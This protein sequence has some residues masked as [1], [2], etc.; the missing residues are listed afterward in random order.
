MNKTFPQPVPYRS[1]PYLKASVKVIQID[2]T[3][4]KTIG[5]FK[6]EQEASRKTGYDQSGISKCI[7]NTQTLC[8]GYRWEILKLKALDT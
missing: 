4:N 5:I 3:T 6:S 8:G 2:P 7:N 1:V